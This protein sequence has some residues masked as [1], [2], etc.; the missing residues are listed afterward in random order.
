MP[1]LNPNEH[2]SKPWRARIKQYNKD[3]FLGSFATKAEALKVEKAARAF[4]NAEVRRDN[5]EKAHWKR[6]SAGKKY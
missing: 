4:Y 6:Y 5:P 1:S 2:P 3:Q